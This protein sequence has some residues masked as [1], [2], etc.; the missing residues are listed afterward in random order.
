MDGDAGNPR[1]QRALWSSQMNWQ[2]MC[3]SLPSLSIQANQ[4]SDLAQCNANPV[5]MKTTGSSSCQLLSSLC[6]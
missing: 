4:D 3:P 1:K 6:E 2:L 5:V